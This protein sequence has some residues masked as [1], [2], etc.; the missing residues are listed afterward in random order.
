MMSDVVAHGHRAPAA[1]AGYDV[2]GKTGT[3][4]KLD[5]AT[6]ALLA[7]ARRALVRGFVPADDPRLTMLVLLDEPKNE[8]WGSEAAAPIFAAIGRQALRHLNVPPRDSARCRRARRD[9]GRGLASR[10]PPAVSPPRPLAA[11]LAPAPPPAG[12][13]A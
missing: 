8:K 5:P 11:G 1:I 3:A 13:P 6:R 7:R 10:A 4:Q 9:R 12:E 2:A